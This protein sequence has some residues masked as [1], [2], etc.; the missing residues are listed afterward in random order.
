MPR[1]KETAIYIS[2]F[3]SVTNS[4]KNAQKQFEFYRCMQRHGSRLS[5][6]TTRA[7]AI[8]YI[9][10]NYISVIQI[11]TLLTTNLSTFEWRKAI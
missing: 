5:N 3:I 2:L 11:S 7:L 9:T 8:S 6:T 10:F 1:V 4:F